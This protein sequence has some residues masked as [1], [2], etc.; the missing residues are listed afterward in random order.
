MNLEVPPPRVI[1][2]L[3]IIICM[4]SK[5]KTSAYQFAQI[6]RGRGPLS[7]VESCPRQYGD[8]CYAIGSINQSKDVCDGCRSGR[9]EFLGQR[10]GIGHSLSQTDY[11]LM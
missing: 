7:R 4:T 11:R 2:D 8:R 6:W 10:V 5:L 9:S 1:D 3:T